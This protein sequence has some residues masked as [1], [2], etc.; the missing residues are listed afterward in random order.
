[1]AWL[2]WEKL[3]APKASGGM[4]FKSLKEFNLAILAKQRQ[5][6]LTYHVLKSKSF[7][8]YDFSQATLGSNPSF[9]WRSIMAA[10]DIVNYGLCWRIGNGEKIKVWG[11]KWLPTPSTYQVTSPRM[12]LQAKTLVCD[13]IDR[14]KACQKTKAIDALFLPHEVEEIKKIP[15][16]IHLPVD[17]QICACSPN[18]LF[19][20]R[21][22]YWVAREMSRPR[23]FNFGLDGGKNR[24]FWTKIWK[25]QVPHKIRQ[26]WRGNICIA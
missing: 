18:G 4:G 23:N 11:D 17:K 1:M 20:V 6:S 12:F 26:H 25:I 15:L 2:G 13:L 9:T 22:A 10:Q 14:E 24:Q 8:N 19:T 3:C 7:P 16:S 5:N 21:S